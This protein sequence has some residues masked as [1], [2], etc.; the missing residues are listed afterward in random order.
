[1][2]D[3]PIIRIG[4]VITRSDGKE[5]VIVDDNYSNI[6]K[7]PAGIEKLSSDLKTAQYLLGKTIGDP[8]YPNSTN[9]YIAN[10][11]ST[12]YA[13]K[14]EV[15]D[16]K[17]S[18]AKS[19]LVNLLNADDFETAK[20][21]FNGKYIDLINR[22]WFEEKY[23]E[24]KRDYIKRQE[25]IRINAIRQAKN[26]ITGILATYD[27]ERAKN[28][29]VKNYKELLDSDWFEEQV[30]FYKRQQIENDW[31]INAAFFAQKLEEYDFKAADTRTPLLNLDKY[32]SLKAEYIAKW[33]KSSVKIIAEDGKYEPYTIDIEQATA[34]ADTRKNILVAAR[35]GS[36]KT[37]TLVAKVILLIAKYGIFYN[38]ILIFTF[39]KDAKEE[40][41]ERLKRIIV[42]GKPLVDA[43]DIAYTFHSFAHKIVYD[44][45]SEQE[46][47]GEI[48]Y[49]KNRSRFVQAIIDE[50]P[51]EKI[52]DFFR[53]EAMENDKGPSNRNE[54]YE[55]LRD[56]E[57]YDTLSGI[58]VRSQTEKMICDYLFEHGIKFQYENEI[59]YKQAL[60]KIHKYYILSNRLL[61][62]IFFTLLF[63]Q[64]LCKYYPLFIII[65]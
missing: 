13:D 40:I 28:E 38:D 6:V 59:F 39:N 18:E 24:A 32:Y 16:R 22:R 20:N 45:C 52:F 35:A 37:R 30:E 34:I 10:V 8:Y 54:L 11:K 65:I 1:M 5:F 9:Y 14:V 63:N 53:S 50:L 4:S 64:Y 27:F 60:S 43:D 51:K 61:F 12:N 46:K 21:L 48:L 42:D 15:I 25:N 56:L 26:T 17:V 31:D 23:L 3:K 49:G 19:H 7:A 47:Y 57:R 44:I 2:N 33:F 62:F 36:G 41:N 58:T 55:S 29:F